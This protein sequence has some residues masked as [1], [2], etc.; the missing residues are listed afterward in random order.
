M[1]FERAYGA[2][3]Y[4]V[5]E[6]SRWQKIRVLVHKAIFEVCVGR[7]CSYPDRLEGV[8]FHLRGR[9]HS[10]LMWGYYRARRLFPQAFHPFQSFPIGKGKR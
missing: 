3:K 10:L 4:R 9:T 1:R 2:A 5:Y 7:H 6:L 8:R